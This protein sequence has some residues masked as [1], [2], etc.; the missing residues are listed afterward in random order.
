MINRQQ[1]KGIT[2]RNKWDFCW[3]YRSEKSSKLQLGAHMNTWR[4]SSLQKLGAC[5]EIKHPI[6]TLARTLGLLA[7]RPGHIFFARLV[8]L[9]NIDPTYVWCIA[10]EMRRR[11]LNSWRIIKCTCVAIW[12]IVTP[13]PSLVTKDGIRHMHCTTNI[14]KNTI[15]TH[16]IH[17]T[18]IQTH[19][20]HLHNTPW[21]TI[22]I[23]YTITHQIQK[24][25]TFLWISRTPQKKIAIIVTHGWT[26]TQQSKPARHHA[27]CVR[28][29]VLPSKRPSPTTMFFAQSPMI[30]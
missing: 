22:H 29:T 15:H 16:L 23:W 30:S 21:Y 28:H 9:G 8:V 18:Y 1:K 10:Q 14:F 17:N 25:I 7:M 27:P 12:I 13:L 11:T 5:N 6:D 26:F 20:I 4:F 24:K 19:S 2:W 3:K